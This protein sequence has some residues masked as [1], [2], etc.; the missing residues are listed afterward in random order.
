MCVCVC[1]LVLSHF[2]PTLS[3]LKSDAFFIRPLSR[4]MKIGWQNQGGFYGKIWIENNST[5]ICIVLVFRE[6]LP[7]E[8]LYSSQLQLVSEKKEGKKS[9]R[10]FVH[11]LYSSPSSVVFTAFNGLPLDSP[12]LFSNLANAVTY[13]TF[14]TVK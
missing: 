9:T 8:T 6:L 11:F 4:G 10:L 3:W 1:V 7:I 5:L 2:S 13:V 14:H 12:L